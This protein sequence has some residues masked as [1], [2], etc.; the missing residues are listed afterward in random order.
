MRY[1]FQITIGPVQEFIATA[2]RSRDLW[3]G[4]FLLSELSRAAAQAIPDW[5]NQLIF[6]A[7]NV[8][9]QAG[10]DAEY[11]PANVANKIVAVIDTDDVQ[12]FGASIEQA[13]L[14]QLRQQRDKAFKHIIWD[15]AD[16]QL[17]E[18][19]IEDMLEC[20]WAAVPYDGTNY[21][22]QRAVLEQLLAARK[23]T[24]SFQQVKLSERQGHYPK[25]S[26]DGQRESVIPESAYPQRS[27]NASERKR[28]LADLYKHFGAKQ[29]E[30]LSGVDLLKRHGRCLATPDK[31]DDIFTDFPSTSHFAALPFL[32][33]LIAQHNSDKVRTAFQHYR[34]GLEG[35]ITQNR[36]VKLEQL[37]RRYHCYL[38]VLE[39]YDASILYETRL[40]E[41][42][43]AKDEPTRQQALHLLQEFFHAAANDARPGAYYALLQADGD[44]MGQVIDNQQSADEHRE[45]SQKLAE[46][47]G[48][49]REIVEGYR[50]ALIYAG[51]DDVLAFLPVDTVLKCAQTLHTHFDEMVGGQFKREESDQ[52][53]F[54]TAKQRPA[55]LSVGIA[56]CHH[57]EPLSEA[58]ALVRRAEQ[59]AKHVQDRQGQTV[60][61][62]LAIAI[63]KRS[64]EP[65][66]ISGRWNDPDEKQSF[67]D[68]LNEC[69]RLMRNR[70]LS[71]GLP[72]ELRDLVERLDEPKHFAPEHTVHHRAIAEEAGRIL[73]RKRVQRG[74]QNVN[75]ETINVVRKWLG[76]PEKRGGTLTIPNPR[77][78]YGIQRMTVRQLADELIVARE[79]A[80]YGADATEQ[81]DAHQ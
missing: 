20:Y 50:G 76:L 15:S 1:L 33:Q 32:Q 51:G 79:L 45:L 35:L 57:L 72:Y 11:E 10:S 17:A 9:T 58:L 47:A 62:G 18:Q 23:A 61:N 53:R 81:K 55:T 40:A 41:E 71:A 4:S 27:D 30:R 66:L 43:D 6:P 70:E 42:I 24:R 60:K 26:L 13:I 16:R 68:R 48:G 46:F 56:I 80:R 5:Q 2:R 69:V 39:Y 73:E 67:F 59:A 52:P 12:Q 7:P 3:F 75:E 31:T 54:V 25:S 19:Q 44:S 74:E 21:S 64:G 36:M 29:G 8:I 38:P 78:R 65:Q 28:K 63:E 34:Q 77:E 14:K 22:T 37:N 49:V